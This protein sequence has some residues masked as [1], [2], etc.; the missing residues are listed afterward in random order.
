MVG[1]SVKGLL[2]D[3]R[4]VPEC[5]SSRLHWVPPPPPRMRVWL[6]PPLGPGGGVTLACRE[7]GGGTQFRRL[8]TVWTNTLVLVVKYEERRDE[9]W[10]FL[11]TVQ[12]F[13]DAQ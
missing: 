1:W 10:I 2:F 4:R 6:P 3:I 5:L 11:Y 8:D 13:L 12:P 7:G 9:S